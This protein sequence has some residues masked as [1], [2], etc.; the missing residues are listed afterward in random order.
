MG[1]TYSVV[2]ANQENIN[3]NELKLKVDSLLKEVNAQMSTYIFDSE[4]SKFNR[5][6]SLAPFEVSEDFYLVVQKSQEIFTLSHKAF[7][8]SIGELIEL[9]GFGLKGNFVAPDDLKVKQVLKSVGMDKVELLSGL[10]FKKKDP[11]F[12][13]NLSAIAK[14]FGVDK[15]AELIS[16]YSQD[17]LVEIGGE[18]YARGFKDPSDKKM[19]RVGIEKPNFEGQKKILKASD[20]KDQCVASSGNYRNYHDGIGHTIDPRTGYP[21]QN[22]VLATTVFAVNCMQADAIATALMVLGIKGITYFKN[23]SGLLL[24]GTADKFEE[25]KF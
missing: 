6:N 11:N 21:G 15:V 23:I 18:V 13:I 24:I 19:W 2:I 1:T 12:K 9:W 14:G 22:K 17:F 3:I 5:F 20:L 4:I 8:P 16:K 7:D 10:K 25:V